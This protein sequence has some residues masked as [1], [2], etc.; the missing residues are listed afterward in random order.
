[1]RIVYVRIPKYVATME[2]GRYSGFTPGSDARPATPD[3]TGTAH[4]SAQCPLSSPLSLH[5]H[6]HTGGPLRPPLDI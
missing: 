1:M 3:A 4:A 6:S 5:V 2:F